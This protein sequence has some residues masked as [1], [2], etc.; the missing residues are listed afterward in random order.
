MLIRY[1]GKLPVVDASVF[2]AD[3][4]KLIGDVTVGSMAS[5]WYNAV[6][7]GDLAEIVIGDRTNIQDGVVGHVN[8]SQ[9]LIVGNDVSV[10]HSAIIH[11]C[12]IGHGTLIGMGAIVLNGADIGEYA[13][14]GAGSVVTENKK[15]PPY[16]LSLGSPARVVRE[17]TEEDLQRM[18]R[19][20]ESYVAKG[21]EYRVT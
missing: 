9:P 1:Q 20:A 11:G 13:L 21:K 14:I 5:I 8:T 3:G 10:G 7:R 12:R 4:A 6:L 18:K 19:T 2:V 15:V 16:T 17:L